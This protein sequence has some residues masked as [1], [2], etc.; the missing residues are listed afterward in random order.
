[1]ASLTAEES[2]LRSLRFNSNSYTMRREQRLGPRAG[3]NTHDVGAKPLSICT[4]DPMRSSVL[5]QELTYRRVE[6]KD[7]A[8]PSRGCRK[9]LGGRDRICVT[10][11]RLVS[12]KRDIAEIYRWI[13]FL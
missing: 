8:M 13:D 3:G 4:P 12:G 1:M 9:A 5:D 11:L 10:A 7:R 6:D 2:N